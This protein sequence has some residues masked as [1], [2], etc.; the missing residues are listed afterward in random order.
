MLSILPCD[1]PLGTS[2]I[3]SFSFSFINTAAVLD[4]PSD[5]ADRHAAAD[6]PKEMGLKEMGS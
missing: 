2:I 5:C 1:P 6:D 3:Y 4:R